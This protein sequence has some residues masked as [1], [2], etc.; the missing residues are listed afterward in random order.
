MAPRKVSQELLH[1]GASLQGERRQ[2]QSGNPAL[3][4]ALH[5]SHLL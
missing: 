2:V 5:G 4:A 1:I 3:G